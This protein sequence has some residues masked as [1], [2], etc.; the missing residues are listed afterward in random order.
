MKAYSTQRLGPATSWANAPEPMDTGMHGVRVDD[1]GTGLRVT[2]TRR[3]S[4]LHVNVDHLDGG[5][6]RE[7]KIAA[8]VHSQQAHLEVKLDD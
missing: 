2:I 4:Y 5:D 6:G 7:L 3:D 1:E 8:N